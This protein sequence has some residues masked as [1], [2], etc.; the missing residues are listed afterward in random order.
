M[1]DSETYRD[2]ESFDTRWCVPSYIWYLGGPIFTI[3][4]W[5]KVTE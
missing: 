1:D 2:N 4:G 5:L 3:V